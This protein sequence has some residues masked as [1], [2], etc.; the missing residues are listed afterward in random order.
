[1]DP[2]QA[3]AFLEKSSGTRF[4]PRHVDAFKT[5]VGPWPPGSVVRLSSNEIGV[6]T[7]TGQRPDQPVV[8]MVVDENGTTLEDRWDLDLAEDEVQGRQVA[9]VVD[10]AL[11]DLSA[12]VVFG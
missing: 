10:P 12:S 3:L 7:R 9:G 5:M 8:L 1:M 2:V 4:D 11:Y 6:V